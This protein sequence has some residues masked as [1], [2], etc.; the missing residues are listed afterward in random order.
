MKPLAR[1]IAEGDQVGLLVMID[2]PNLAY[3]KAL[4]SF[5]PDQ[6]AIREV[7]IPLA[8]NE[9]GG[10]QEDPGFLKASGRGSH[11][12]KRACGETKGKPPATHRPQHRDT[13]SNT[14]S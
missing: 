7:A 11:G 2:S 5:G 6:L 13:N 4:E 10:S 14:P 8:G 1:S 3:D 9:P 12:F